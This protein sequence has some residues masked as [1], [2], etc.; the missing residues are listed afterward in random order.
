MKL[1]CHSVEYILS[2]EV[3][4]SKADSLCILYVR[5][6]WYIDRT[7]NCFS[8]T[9]I[10]CVYYSF[11]YILSAQRYALVDR[12][13][14]TARVIKTKYCLTKQNKKIRLPQDSHNDRLISN[15]IDPN[16]PSPARRKKSPR[17]RRRRGSTKR[18][19]PHHPTA[20]LARIPMTASNDAN[21]S[22]KSQ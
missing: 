22:I 13:T 14:P 15:F 2:R 8:R 3:I 20:T 7:E 18:L 4:I 19:R 9:P 5:I 10:R 1:N 6:R 21:Q 12:K 11:L 17:R 16:L